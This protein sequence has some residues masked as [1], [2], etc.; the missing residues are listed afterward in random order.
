MKT[1]SEP[2]PKD[3][4]DSFVTPPPQ[5]SGQERRAILALSLGETTAYESDASVHDVFAQRVAET[6]HAIAV[7]HKTAKLTYA[8][9]DRRANQLAR[10]L[11]AMGIGPRNVGWRS[12]R[13]LAP[14]PGGSPCHSQGRCDLRPVRPVLSPRAPILHRPRRERYVDPHGRGGARMDPRRGPEYRSHRSRVRNCRTQ[15][16]SALDESKRADTPAYVMY[17]SGSTGRPKGV[18]VAHRS[19]VRLV[20]A[21]N[22]ADIG[23]GDTVLQYAPLAFDAS[24]FEI[25]APLLN[26]GQL[27]IAPAGP[28]PF[29]N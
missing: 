5:L 2:L 13:A 28:L 9:L 6:P 3:W 29:G 24:T 26:G 25:W 11:Q 22:Y 15:S 17:T 16:E 10:Y 18:V 1:A 12:A 20:R 7:L 27:A 4:Q 19:I 21:T 14:R 23:A 8:E